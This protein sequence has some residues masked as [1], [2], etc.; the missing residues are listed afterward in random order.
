MLDVIYRDLKPENILV[1]KDGHIMLT[2]FDLS[3]RCAVNP[4]LLRS[5]SPPEKDPARMSGPYNTSNCIQPLCIEPSCRVPCFSP[6][7]LSTQDRNQKPRKPKRPD[8]L[9][10]QFRSLPQLV[11]EP[12]ESRCI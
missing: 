1:R 4:T 3:L 10:Q 7:L 11:A 9:T 12:T 8:L 5:T 2:D 6:R